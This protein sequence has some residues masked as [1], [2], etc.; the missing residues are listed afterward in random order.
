MKE[1]WTRVPAKGR[2]EWS[3]SGRLPHEDMKERTD[4]R[5][6]SWSERE[7]GSE[8]PFVYR[9]H[10]SDF[11]RHAMASRVGRDETRH[12]AGTR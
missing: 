2:E 10:G 5:V 6:G 12:A 4:E 1:G 8:M 9:P 7:G 3:R 11:C